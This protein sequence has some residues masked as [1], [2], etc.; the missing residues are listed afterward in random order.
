MSTA[1]T[2][3][4]RIRG[5]FLRN[6][7][8]QAYVFFGRLLMEK[9]MA[10]IIDERQCGR[11]AYAA[12]HRSPWPREFLTLAIVA[13]LVVFWALVLLATGAI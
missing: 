11:N 1:L 3:R 13:G 9:L 10:F 4:C 7:Y 8:R 12:P 6:G 5:Q 2:Q